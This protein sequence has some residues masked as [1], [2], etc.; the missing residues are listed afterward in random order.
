VIKDK[1]NTKV[2]TLPSNASC[3]EMK[4]DVQDFFSGPIAD[5]SI[6]CPFCTDARISLETSFDFEK[7]IEQVTAAIDYETVGDYI[8]A[9]TN[10]QLAMLNSNLEVVALSPIP[11]VSCNHM[12]Y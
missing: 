7:N 8:V 12:A 11:E 4:L 9:L 5:Y 6:S 10:N 1:P 3:L 2:I